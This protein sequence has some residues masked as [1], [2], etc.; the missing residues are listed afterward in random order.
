MKKKLVPQ[1][2]WVLV[3]PIEEGEQ[4]YGAL[5]LPD[6]GK[7]RPLLGKVVAVGDGD[8]NLYGHYVRPTSE[9]GDIVLLPKVKTI[10]VDFEGEEYYLI[11][12]KE[13]L[14]IVVE[15]EESDF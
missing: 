1:K 15:E 11:P 10:R 5:I 3:K 9:T 4:T 13:I 12:D 6:L 7:E 8:Y 14:A 2:D